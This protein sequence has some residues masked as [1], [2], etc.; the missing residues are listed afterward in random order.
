MKFKTY[1]INLERS[2][3]RKDYMVQQLL[4]LGIASQRI[5]AVDG[6]LLDRE[7]TDY[8]I[9]NQS[10]ADHFMAPKLGEI[11]AFESHRLSW[12]II[13][14]Q[15]EDFALV[16]EDD[17]KVSP[18][19][20]KDISLILD[21]ITT[22]DIVDV[23]GRKGFIIDSE[24]VLNDDLKLFKYSTPPLGMTGKII[25]RDAAKTLLETFPL[26]T[27]PVDVMVQ[28]IY[29]HQVSILSVNKIY[30]S[31][32]DQELGGTT[33]QSKDISQTQKVFRE[34]KRPFWRLAI[35]IMNYIGKDK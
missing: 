19:F 15:V 3:E 25:G 28:K 17:I 6:A 29:Q 7:Y 11:G 1:Y 30:L 5:N 18:E 16:L 4:N 33:I 9:A 12:D 13:S 35:K 34:L 24:L 23:S 20:F 10:L 14:K 8:I 26:Y 21:N 31:H 32:I 27:A 2:P 22:S